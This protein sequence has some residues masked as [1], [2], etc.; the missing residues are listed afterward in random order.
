M[1][2]A[3]IT[4]KADVE[5]SFDWSSFLWSKHNASET[6]GVVFAP[7]PQFVLLNRERVSIV[8]SSGFLILIGLIVL[9]TPMLSVVRDAWVESGMISYAPS[10]IDG[11]SGWALGWSLAAALMLGGFIHEGG[12]WLS[13]RLTGRRLKAFM[14][15]SR[16]SVAADRGPS[17]SYQR[18][19]TSAAGG[20]FEAAFGLC[21]LVTQGGPGW[22]G[23]QLIAAA[24][25]LNG[26]TNILL[27]LRRDSDGWSVWSSLGSILIGRGGRSL[28]R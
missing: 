8:L 25:I 24:V 23:L 6:R 3:D 28:E 27:P 13:Y 22:N 26:L 15:G 1:S 7:H 20:I 2:T 10:A 17:N 16:M 21:I 14:I 5:G 9:M 11:G 4:P 12:H 18:L 19:L